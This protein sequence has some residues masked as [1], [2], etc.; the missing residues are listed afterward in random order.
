MASK[1]NAWVTWVAGTALLAAVSLW[2]R[3]LI[4]VDETRYAT[5]AWEMWQGGQFVLPSLNGGLYEHKPPLLFWLVHLGWWLT[6]VSETWPRLIGPL[7]LLA[8]L[9]LITRLAARLWPGLPG[10]G[11]TASLV[12]LGT[13]TFAVY[14]SA[15]MFDLPL[16]VFLCLG[17]ISLHDAVRTGRWRDWLFF[18]LAFA[19][20][21][22]TKGPVA[23]VY[24]LPPLLGLRAWAPAGSAPL[25]GVRLAAALALAIGLPL[26]WLVLANDLSG[27]EL[28]HRVVHEQT[29][30][31]VQGELGHPRP[32]YWYLPW[33]P[34]LAMPWVLWPPAWR[35]LRATAAA[36]GDRGRR[37][38]ALTVAT[39]FVILSL[40]G[41]KQV[42][43]LIPLLALL[44]LW[45]ARGLVAVPGARRVAL[46]GLALSVLAMSGAFLALASRY[47]LGQASRYVGQQQQ[48]GRRVAYIGH[49]QGEFGFL[50][51]LRSPV[52]ALEPGDA[53][54]WARQHP[55]DLVV[56]RDK[57][58]QA[59]PAARPEF[60]QL[61]KTG[62]LMMYRAAHLAP[63]P[64]PRRRQAAARTSAPAA[65]LVENG[66]QVGRDGHGSGGADVGAAG[67][68][69]GH[70]KAGEQ[71]RCKD[72][73]ALSGHLAG[74]APLP[75]YRQHAQVAAH[76]QAGGSLA[77]D[78]GALE[79]MEGQV[80]VSLLPRLAGKGPLGFKGLAQGGGHGGK[81]SEASP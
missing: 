40:V 80:Q 62:E 4:P 53:A 14:G 43:Y 29:L 54:A 36:H 68:A 48:A 37:F 79:M 21:M 72:A 44:S 65:G 71:G 16:L 74:I 33:L 31:R 1:Q 27:G 5:V 32:V 24:L 19:A 64:V 17:W 12:C 3:P 10:I 50:G 51:R 59:T 78:V 22:L 11:A 28:L 70:P 23:A 18:G 69:L 63:D 66:L 52:I 47:D 61:Y 77:Q 42:H 30:G 13:T 73:H 45:L 58:L 67:V 56:V 41:G 9:W 57:R 20:A 55:D 75:A 8:N 46:G 39:G 7:A 35:A 34:L 26:A 49:Y 60:R 2:L 25:A 15:L 38:I 6:G 81:P 76:V